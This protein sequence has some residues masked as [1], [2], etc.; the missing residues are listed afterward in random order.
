ML[1]SSAFLPCTYRSSPRHIYGSARGLLSSLAPRRSIEFYFDHRP[2]C[3]LHICT[4]VCQ[5]PERSGPITRLDFTARVP[6]RSQS[7][8]H[9]TPIVTCSVE[10]DGSA[11]TT[12][13]LLLTTKPRRPSASRRVAAGANP[14]STQKHMPNFASC[15]I[16][17]LNL[18]ASWVG[19]VAALGAKESSATPSFVG[20]S[21]FCGD[22][23]LEPM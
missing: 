16:P 8:V 23:I 3:K 1:A 9:S 13:L 12:L 20:K 10:E 11:H 15:R 14:P 22:S 6:R 18:L 2:P 4:C 19:A 21:S 7:K 5:T 17:S